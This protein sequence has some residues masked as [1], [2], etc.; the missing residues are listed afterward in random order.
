[1]LVFYTRVYRKT[2]WWI[3][4]TSLCL[5]C[6]IFCGT[7]MKKNKPRMHSISFKFIVLLMLLVFSDCIGQESLDKMTKRLGKVSQTTF[8]VNCMTLNDTL[9]CDQTEVANIDWKEYMSY[10]KRLNGENSEE[11]LAA[12]PDT[13]GYIL[14]ITGG[15][16]LN[17]KVLKS[18]YLLSPKYDSYP[19]VGVTLSQVQLYSKWRSDRVFQMMLVHLNIIK[20]NSHPIPQNEFT[21]E[22]FLKSKKAKKN[23]RLVAYYPLYFIPDLKDWEVLK[24][25]IIR[26]EIQIGKI[27]SSRRSNTLQR[28]TDIPFA[29]TRD[30]DKPLLEN[31]IY[32]ALG[33]VSEMI[34]EPNK[35]IGG[36]Y[37]D[38]LSVILDMK[39]VVVE[40]PQQ[41]VGFRNYCKWI[42]IDPSKK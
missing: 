6:T 13:T 8:P 28:N 26:K 3:Y 21:I 9:M 2:I 18:D 30:Y 40:L 20:Y 31:T 4:N 34:K 5:S 24:E 11:Y 1:M 17:S 41:N 37:Q 35:A 23:I 29:V 39:E 32:N 27:N 38:E 12:Y 10:I 15:D 25:K 42:K 36:S 22:K 19:L 33:N 16:S 7:F 14:E